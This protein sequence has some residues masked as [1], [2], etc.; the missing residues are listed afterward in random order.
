MGCTPVGGTPCGQWGAEVWYAWLVCGDR[1]GERDQDRDESCVCVWETWG[2]SSVFLAG[3]GWDALPW[4]GHLA[5]SGVQKCGMRGS[6]VVIGPVSEIKTGMRV[7]FV[8]GRHGK[9]VVCF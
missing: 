5:G 9:K 4:G 8:C 7:A 2:E 3:D 6:C 1:A